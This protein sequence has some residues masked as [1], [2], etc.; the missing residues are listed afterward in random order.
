MWQRIFT[1]EKGIKQYGSNDYLK[2]VEFYSSGYLI[3]IEVE[4]QGSSDVYFDV[5]VN[6]K[7][8]IVE[9]EDRLLILPIEFNNIF[10]LQI[11]DYLLKFRIDS[12]ENF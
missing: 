12:L 1:N 2:K 6:R 4:K 7:Y 3:E 9:F 5:D 11:K 8:V 10:R